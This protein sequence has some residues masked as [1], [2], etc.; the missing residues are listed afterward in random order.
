MSVRAPVGPTNMTDRKI[1]IGR[2]LAA[3]RC[4]NKVI[5]SFVLYALKNIESRIVGNDGA[6]FNSI[7]KKMIEELPLPQCSI[8]E[9]ERIVERLDAAFAQ[10]DELKTMPKSNSQ[11]LVPSSNLPSPKPCNPNLTGKKKPWVILQILFMEKTKKK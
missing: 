9:Q 6:V 2:G 7:N 1:C 3:I 10:I 8:V 4:T 11:R 5:P